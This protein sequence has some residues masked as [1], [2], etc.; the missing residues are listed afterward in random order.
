LAQPLKQP[1][2]YTIGH[3]TQPVEAFLELL[4]QY[5]I[6]TIIDVRSV[7]YS[8]FAFHYNQ[9]NIKYHLQSNNIYY[10]YMGDS[11]GARYT[12]R[13][14]FFDDMNKVDFSKVQQ[15]TRFQKAISRVLNGISKGY[16]IAL[17]CAE[18]EAFNCHRFMLICSYLKQHHNLNIAHIYPDKLIFQ[19]ELEQKMIQKYQKYLPTTNLF[20]D[21]SY[22]EQ[23]QLAYKLKNRDIVSATN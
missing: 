19:D 20:C 13:K 3:S 22:D 21:I 15:T 9:D 18:K 17:M 1:Q 4:Y 8:K 11:L 6:D 2:I 12:D 14:L 7:P 16:K 10:I 23:L 5:G